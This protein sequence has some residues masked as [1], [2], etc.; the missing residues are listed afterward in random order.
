MGKQRAFRTLSSFLSDLRNAEE[1]LKNKKSKQTLPT[2]GPM[3]Y[4]DP[5]FS[6]ISCKCNKLVEV[7]HLTKG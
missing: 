3:S 4:S 1:F 2:P 5:E 7:D 6:T